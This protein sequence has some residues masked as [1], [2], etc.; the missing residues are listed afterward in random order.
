M[1]KN[2]DVQGRGGL[3][4]I[5]PNGQAYS[6][7]LSAHNLAQ[8]GVYSVYDSTEHGKQFAGISMTGA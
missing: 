5:V 8:F 7:A 4:Y 1:P 2:W 6:Q 3:G